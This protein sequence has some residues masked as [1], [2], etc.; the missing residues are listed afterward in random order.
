M[1]SPDW[2]VLEIVDGVSREAKIFWGSQGKPFTKAKQ[3]AK[4]YFE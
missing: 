4:E 1:E 3:W 2:Q